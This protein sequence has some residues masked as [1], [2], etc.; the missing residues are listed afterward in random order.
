MAEGFPHDGKS[1]G[2]CIAELPLE[3]VLG[4]E[5]MASAIILAVLILLLASDSFFVTHNVSSLQQHG[6]ALG[7]GPVRPAQSKLHC[8][9]LPEQEVDRN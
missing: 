1:C 2:D 6:E 4:K 5:G 9:G 3:R 7:W 8:E